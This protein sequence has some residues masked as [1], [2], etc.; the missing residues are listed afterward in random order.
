[1]VIDQTIATNA[2]IKFFNEL[3]AIQAE[4]RQQ[5]ND[6]LQSGKTMIFALTKISGDINPRRVHA[7][8]TADG[9]GCHHCGRS[10]HVPDGI[11]GKI[12]QVPVVCP[13]C[14]HVTLFVIQEVF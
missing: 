9:T 11:P 14:E 12:L 4:H 1:M 8:N 3:E 5:L 6:R 13:V 2:G 10:L 7:V